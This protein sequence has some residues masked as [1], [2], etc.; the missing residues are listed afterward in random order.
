M[1]HTSWNEKQGVSGPVTALAQTTDGYLWIGTTD[2]LLRFDGISFEHFR[3]EGGPL[4]A[5]SVSTLMA[6]PDGG[7]WVGFSRGGASF[8]KNGLVRNYSDSDGFPVSGVRSLARDRSGTIWAAVVGGFARLEGQR[9]VRIRGDWNYP[10]KSA[11]DLL[12]DREGTLWVATGSQILFLPNGKKQ[13]RDTGIHAGK[14][15]GLVQAPDG[16]IWFCDEGRKIY[17]FRHVNDDKIERSPELD[18]GTYSILFDR[19]GG[20]WVGG[21]MDSNGV[22]RIPFPAKL[23]NSI[24]SD[25]IERFKESDGLS[26]WNATTLLEDREGNIWV[27]TEAGLDRFRLRNVR[28]FSLVGRGGISLIAGPGGVVWAG[29]IDKYPVIQL[30]DQDRA[31]SGGPVWVRT[32]FRDSDGSIWYGADNSLLHWQNGRFVNV[33]VPHQVLEVSRSSTPPDAIIA[34]A[35]TKDRSGSLWVAFG[36]SGEF[37][38]KD[39]VWGFVPILPDHSDWSAAYAFTDE[40]DRIWFSFGDRVACDDHGNIQV[41]GA[42]DGLGI[43]PFTVI[44]GRGQQIWVGGESGLSIFQNGRFHTIHRDDGAGFV[45]VNGIVRTRNGGV[46]LSTGQGIVHIP[47]SEVTKLIQNPEHEV[48]FDLFDLVSD[49]PEPIQRWA[50]IYSSD[51][52]QA[53][54]GTLW[55]AARGGAVQIDPKNIYRNPLP[56]P[57][58]IRSVVADGKNYSPFTPP[59]LPPLTKSLQI[60]YAALSL[61]IPERVRFRYKLDG[62]DKEWHEDGGHRDASF[63][64]LGPGKYSFRVIACNNDGVWNEQG[65]TLDF[66]VTPTWYQTIWFQMVCFASACWLAWALHRFRLQ[67]VAKALNARFNERLAERT[68][69]ARELHDTLLQSLHGLM[70][71]FQAVRNMF[72]T[73]PEEAIQ[74]LDNA[75]GG[76]ERAISESQDA[77]Q[78]LRSDAVAENDL[79]KLLTETGEGLMPARGKTAGSPSFRLVLEGAPRV[80][81]PIFQ[82]EVYRIARELLRNAVRHAQAHQIEAEI[83]YESRL[84]RLSVR[85][86]GIGMDSRVLEEG[87]AGHWGLPGVRER[88]RRIGAQIDFWTEA[89]A[90]TEVRLTA[91][92]SVAYKT[93]RS[94]TAFGLF[95]KVK[96]HE[97]RS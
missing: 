79:A 46:W 59:N 37:R 86:D 27:G 97:H 73:R 13:F 54:D 83:R 9:W 61:S 53:N 69:I 96:N 18:F 22:S 44:A 63:T 25:D 21:A 78:G 52:I 38:L 33:P 68:R 91:A 65:A 94:R 19:D 11:W 85:D 26:N 95:R 10:A 8:I 55:F 34:S 36:G 88:A 90:G 56:P 17:S 48:A 23:H 7:L 35:I 77:I 39:G 32:A 3:P 42:K 29:S 67:R 82:D 5:T 58:S 12:V 93:L 30:P 75:I 20:L 66:R 64:N 80:L 49:L 70:F 43:G 15:W 31:L 40:A 14:V 81:A 28:W 62:W 84:F 72:D 71:E 47:E 57:V 24:L 1:Y 74:V 87:R 92:A 41:F 45:S 60:E 76:T 16:A 89:G 50:G 51:A 6:V 2:G 4:V